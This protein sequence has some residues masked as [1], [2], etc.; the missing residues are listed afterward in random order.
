VWGEPRVPPQNLIHIFYFSST[1][2]S[3]YEPSD[4][5]EN[6][7]CHH[8][9]HALLKTGSRRG[10][11]CMNCCTKENF[12]DLHKGKQTMTLP[13]VHPF[14]LRF[15]LGRSGQMMSEDY[16]AFRNVN[17]YLI[18]DLAKRLNKDDMLSFAR[19]CKRFYGI[20]CDL[21]FDERSYSKYR[22]L[23]RLKCVRNLVLFDQ[24]EGPVYT[25]YRLA[26]GLYCFY[27]HNRESPVG[28]F[29]M[30]FDRSVKDNVAPIHCEK[31]CTVPYNLSP[32]RYI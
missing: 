12:C 26:F 27:R 13:Y 3:M 22:E 11:R 31:P 9:C 4:L 15:L 23:C 8:R 1:F 28:C 32:Y 16:S 30:C 6:L 7:S 17:D 5:L 25:C 19:T 21:L 14:E 10:Q 24:I 18:R 2:R 29:Y 20:F